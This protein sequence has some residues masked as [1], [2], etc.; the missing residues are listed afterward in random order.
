MRKYSSEIGL[1]KFQHLSFWLEG[2]PSSEH[3]DE[4][5]SQNP[6]VH[7]TV[8]IIPVLFSVQSDHKHSKENL[9]AVQSFCP[10]GILKEGNIF[11]M[12]KVI[13]C[14]VLLLSL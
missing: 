14:M 5:A 1:M 6:T 13:S 12:K 3:L 4:F 11:R 8:S 10:L 9:K 2:N 7:N